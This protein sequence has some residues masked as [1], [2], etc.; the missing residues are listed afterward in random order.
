MS[1]ELAPALEED[2]GD[3]PDLA[4]LESV[5]FVAGGPLAIGR[6]AQLLERPP[7]EVE[8]LLQRLQ[9]QYTRRG[10]DVQWSP[11]GVQLTTA[12]ESA[13]V[14]E[15]YLGLETTTRLSQ[16]ALEV[17]A[18]VAYLQP[19]TRPKIDEIRGVN[20]DGALRTLLTHGLIE[21]AGRQETPGRPILYVTTV[22][23]LQLF[24]LNSLAALP[25]LPEA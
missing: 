13:A 22:E 11:Q 9:E 24:G 17:L 6:L 19:V 14:V 25:P 1:D 2:D 15:R 23:F 16:A 21:E 18:L 8:R 5:L 4:R 3:A 20:S 12:P 10:L 7:R